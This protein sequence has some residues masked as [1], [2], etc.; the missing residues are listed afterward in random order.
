M[1]KI[2]LTFGVG[3]VFTVA[4]WTGKAEAKNPECRFG[5]GNRAMRQTIWCVS[6]KL[7]ADGGF[8]RTAL[9]VAGRESG[10]N[11]S[12]TND[13]SGACG[14]YQHIPSYW[15]GRYRA[16]SAP[17]WGAMGSSCYNGRT[18][19]IVGLTMAKRGGWGPWSL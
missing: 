19:I 8:R 12:A 15:P 9:Y 4:M 17:R 13:Y 7:R 18:N 1:K 14:I 5:V 6:H 3:L 16:Y 11:A 2:L 10:F